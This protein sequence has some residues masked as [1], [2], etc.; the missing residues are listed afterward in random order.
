MYGQHF[1]CIIA[2]VV[3]LL[4]LAVYTRSTAAYDAL[5]SFEI[6]QLPLKAT[7]Q[8]Y[9]GAFMHEPGARSECI[10][11]QVARYVLFKEQCR[12]GG[13]QEPISDGVLIF[14]EVKVACQLMWNSRSHQLMG[15]AMTHKEL[16]SL[17]DI[18]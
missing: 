2:S 4:A 14:D 1:T 11:S 16:P 15:L 13:K 10:E 6:L 12:D 9:T 3:Y 18:Y 17:N 7:L 5:K 8:V